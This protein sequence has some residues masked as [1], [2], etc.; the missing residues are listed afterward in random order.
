MSTDQRSG[1]VEAASAFWEAE[2]ARDLLEGLGY[3]WDV[4]NQDDADVIALAEQEGFCW[5][6]ESWVP[7]GSAQ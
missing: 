7:E 4:R 2:R 6:G 3:Q 5:D 1:F